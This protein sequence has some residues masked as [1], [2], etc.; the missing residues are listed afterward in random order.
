MD[1]FEDAGG[2]KICDCL[3]YGDPAD[4][5]PKHKGPF[6]RDGLARAEV[7][8]NQM[9]Q[10]AANLRAFGSGGNRLAI[11]PCVLQTLLLTS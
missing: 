5:Q 3:S 8:V 10:N 9:L 6:G 2:N 1:A 7:G 4:T 11:K